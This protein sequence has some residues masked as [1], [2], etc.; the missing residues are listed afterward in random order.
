MPAIELAD[1]HSAN[2]PVIGVFAP[3]D[4]RLDETVRDRC[5]NIVKIIAD[6]I[7]GRVLLPTGEPCKVVY[8]RTLVDGEKTADI[9]A[10]SFKEA[11]VN[12][13]VGV[14]D[15]WSFPQLTTISLMAHFPKDTPVNLTCGNAGPKPGVV[16]AQATAGAVSQYRLIH[17]NV[18]TW[19]DRGMFPKVT[20]GTID[21]LID[22][23]H[24]AVTKQYLK[25]KRVAVIGHDS[26][27]METAMAHV[28]PVRKQFGLEFARVDMKLISDLMRKEAYCKKEQKELAAWLKD[29][30]AG[31]EL[32]TADDETKF[33]ESCAM[34][35]VLRDFLKD[36]NA[37]GGG[38]MNQLEWGSDKRGIGMATPDIAECFFNSTF[39]H[40]GKKAPVP[41]ATEADMQ[42]MLT[43]LIFSCL[44]AGKAPLFMDFRKV[45][46][47]GEIK[48]LADEK[49]I[50]IDESALW[51][52]KGFVDG[53]NSG[54]AAFDW[55]GMPGDSADAV[56]KNVTFPLAD[57]AYFMGG[58]NSAC[59]HSPGGIEG[60][61]GRMMYSEISGLFSLSWDE[62]VTADIPADMRKE[63]ADL[64]DPTWPH[65]FLTPKYASMNE[66]KH[67]PPANHI[68]MIE[69]LR[70]AVLEYWMDL[71]NVLSQQAWNARPSYIEG[72]DR[73]M[74]LLYLANG[75]ENNTKLM[76]AK[77]L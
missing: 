1:S 38:F 9:V 36:L 75:G 55:A 61:A 28:I 27:G 73:P 50:S 37:I 7:E 15:T 58:G 56:M 70:P 29:K 11:G 40:N 42:G 48:A 57:P 13:L 6:S 47:P 53:N 72:V 41:F 24:A 46:E 3:G 62:A 17:M 14:P 39:D 8:S 43:M 66:Y 54:S 31:V 35:L 5:R 49:G 45:W 4:P 52:A 76:L 68:H 25:G 26:M 20:P 59:F 19:E 74:P 33:E 23:C 30:S 10:A 69:G 60:I 71:T 21:K 12:I 77:K 63:F 16:Y 34:Y 51:A 64:T 2:N 65:T 32:K 67:F 22:W 44:T 18:G